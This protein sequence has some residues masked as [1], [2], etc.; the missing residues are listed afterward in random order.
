VRVSGRGS[1]PSESTVLVAGAINTDLVGR[2]RRSPGAGETVTGSSFAIFGG[3]KGANQAFAAARSD[4]RT[5]MLGAVGDD[6]FGRAR[7][8]DLQAEGIRTDGV[9]T[10]PDMASGVALILVDDGGE[11]RILY[12]PGPTLTISIADAERAVDAFQP[13]LVLLTLEPPLETAGRLIELAKLRSIPVVLNATPEPA[14]A[15]ALLAQ[16]DVLIVN[17]SEASQILDI[18]PGELEWSEAVERLHELGPATVVATLGEQGALVWHDGAVKQI[19]APRVE[20]VDTTGA[21]DSFCGAFAARLVRGD[22]PVTAA[23]YGVAAGSLAV[24][25]AG[26]QPSIPTAAEIAVLLDSAN[27]EEEGENG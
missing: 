6:D 9:A 21:G 26:A 20:V 27:A 12:V 17:E 4:V 3:G 10:R 8:S 5:V 11:N 22:D 18:K 7:L 14:A 15:V 2:A 13:D 1:Q 25:V 19:P 23:R 24:T 16:V